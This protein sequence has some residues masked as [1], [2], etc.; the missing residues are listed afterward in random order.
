MK[1]NQ[2]KLMVFAIA[3]LLLLLQNVFLVK[4]SKAAQD[5][6]RA[7]KARVVELEGAAAQQ[8]S[9]SR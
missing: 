2:V 4:Q 7:L 9:P 5:E 3:F 8:A 6:I 1:S